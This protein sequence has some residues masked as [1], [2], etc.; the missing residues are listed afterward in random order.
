MTGLNILDLL[1]DLDSYVHKNKETVALR[2]DQ[3]N[4]LI[5]QILDM[6][7]ETIKD[8]CI[9]YTQ[10]FFLHGAY[11]NNKALTILQGHL[12]SD[13]RKLSSWT[14]PNDFGKKN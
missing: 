1:T 13:I 12:K 10:R 3:L 7:Y 4:H 14:C 2:L 5:N 11:G 6:G 8:L 9:A